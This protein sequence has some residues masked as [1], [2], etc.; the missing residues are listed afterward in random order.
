MGR[1]RKGCMGEVK[2]GVHGGG[3]GRGACNTCILFRGGW[4]VI[5]NYN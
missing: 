4:G 2:G 5:G 3:E 1:R